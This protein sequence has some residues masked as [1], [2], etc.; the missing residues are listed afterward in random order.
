M[1]SVVEQYIESPT[2]EGLVDLVKLYVNR[3]DAATVATVPFF[4]NAAEKVILRN[5]RMPSMEKIV[6]LTIDSVGNTDECWFPVPSDYLEMKFMW[7]KK[8]TLQRVPFDQIFTYEEDP[9][10]EESYPTNL[11]WTKPV[12]IW[13]ING[14]RVYL[15]GVGLEEELFMTYYKDIEE[16]STSVSTNILLTLVPDAFL[17]LA[18]SECWKFLQEEEKSEMWERKGGQRLSAVMEQVS[19]AEF[20]GSPL[21]IKPAMG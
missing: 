11:P 7:T 20:S 21:T 19:N 16:I 2:Y 13:A 18:V 4:I 9:S 15:K 14:P 5:L 1:T 3:N 17:F 10:S 6:K 12:G 8:G